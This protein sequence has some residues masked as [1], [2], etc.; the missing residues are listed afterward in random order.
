MS[1]PVQKLVISSLSKTFKQKER[2]IQALSEINL[3]VRD[4]EF[5]SILGASGCGKSTLLRII[6]GLETPSEGTV[7]INGS[8]IVDPGADR[9]M[10]F[11]SYTLFP[12]LTVQKN[13]EFGMREKGMPA[14]ERAKIAE[15]YIEIVGL[16]GFENAYPK[17]LSGGMKQRVAIAR[18]LANDPDVIL[19]DEPF[20]AL[21]MQTRSL[22]QELLLDVWQRSQKTVIL[23]THDI[24][25][26][27]FMA[28]RVVVMESR[29]GKIKE[30]IPIEFP[31]PRDYHI[32]TS[33][34]FLDYK[35]QAVELIRNETLKGMNAL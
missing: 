28:D 16:K 15:E 9:G 1:K 3:E 5:V 20:G 8:E 10:V 34:K 24:D 23:V 7:L 29:P 2:T 30:I 19:L 17:A 12:W 11:Q 26:A 14:L 27:I 32:K 22:M 4:K 31:R 35:A 25:E 33:K 21:D 6:G 13:I 18:A